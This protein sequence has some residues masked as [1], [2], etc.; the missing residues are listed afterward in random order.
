M[1][2]NPTTGEL[3][4][5]NAITSDE[6]EAAVDAVLQQP[7]LGPYPIGGYLLDLSEAIEAHEPSA[8]ALADLDRPEKFRRTMARTA[9]LLARPEKG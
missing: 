9:I 8:A 5:A 4:K 6:I 1:A 7:G 2:T 3:Y